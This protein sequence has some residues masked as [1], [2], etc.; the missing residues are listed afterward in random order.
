MDKINA[1]LAVVA[2]ETGLAMVEAHTCR[3]EKS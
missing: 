1:K 3:F 2:R